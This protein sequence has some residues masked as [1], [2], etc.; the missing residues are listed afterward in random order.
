MVSQ[1]TT[2]SLLATHAKLFSLSLYSA[3]EINGLIKFHLQQVNE[4]IVSVGALPLSL[5][6]NEYSSFFLCFGGQFVLIVYINNQ[7]HNFFFVYSV[8]IN[9]RLLQARQVL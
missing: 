7:Y 8:H 9:N 4:M 1:V 5:I 2:Q 6:V 3:D